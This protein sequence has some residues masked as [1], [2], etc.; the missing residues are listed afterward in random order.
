MAA[1]VASALFHVCEIGTLKFRHNFPDFRPCFTLVTQAQGS[2]LASHLKRL[3][4][5]SEPLPTDALSLQTQNRK[6]CAV[7]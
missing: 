5:S 2:L 1:W 3:D 7:L 4:D 6:V